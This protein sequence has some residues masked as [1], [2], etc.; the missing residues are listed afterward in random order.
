MSITVPLRAV[1]TFAG[2][3]AVAAIAVFAFQGLR[4]D[5]APGDS[6]TTFVPTTP[7]RLIDTRPADPVGS[8]TAFGANDTKTIVAHGTNG[9]CTIPS[10]AVGLSLNVTAVGA[11]SPTFLTIWPNGDRPHA[12][13]LNPTPGQPPT[14][15]AVNTGLSDTG[16]F[17]I[18][19][20][21]GNV[22]AI[23]DV[24]GYYT[25]SSL[26]NLQQ[27]LSALE[28]AGIPS[29]VLARLDALE[30]GNVAQQTEIDALKTDN[31]ALKAD[32]VELMAKTAAMSVVDAGA[33]VRFTGVDV[34]IV[35]GTGNTRCTATGVDACSGTGNLIVGY[36][37]DDDDDSGVE[38]RS[39]S[40]NIVTGT[41]NDYQSHS[42]IIAGSN[43]TTSDEYATI[44]GGLSNTASGDYSSVTGGIK[45]TAS[46]YSSSVTGGDSN[47]ADGTYSSVAG[48]INN[49]ADGTYSSVTGGISNNADG[50]ASSVAGGSAN[51]A[52]GTYS[53]VTGGKS[54]NAVGI[55]SSVFGGIGNTVSTEN[56]WAPVVN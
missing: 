46:G 44:T 42:G 3:I 18:F 1:A 16:S 41:D 39:G 6:D 9:K 24:N 5:A 20:L 56:G 7:C 43:N 35:D 8:E 10:E 45:N 19:N 27:R 37:E 29:D 26:T 25:K 50:S 2:G 52:T 11:T 15:N 54:N 51:I 32:N 14:P 53:S 34:Q 30:T 55:Y 12:S 40:H 38:V 13:N 31:V 23:I 49:T 47:T 4:V 22:D 36:N 33:T 48:G 21:A 28:T 17:R